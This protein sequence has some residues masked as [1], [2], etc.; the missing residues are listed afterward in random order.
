MLGTLIVEGVLYLVYGLET[1]I[2]KE[3]LYFDST[4]LKLLLWS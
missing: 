1:L 4:I 2:M 3:G